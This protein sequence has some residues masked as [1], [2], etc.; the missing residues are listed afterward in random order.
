MLFYTNLKSIPNLGE[1][2]AEALA[3]LNIQTISDLLL[4]FPCNLITKK[5]NPP[6]YS[7]K[8][9]DYVILKLKIIDIDLPNDAYKLRRKSFN[10]YCENETGK[11]DLCYFNYHPQYLFNWAKI[12]S[13]I[14][15]VGK[16]E[17]F[18]TFKKIPHPEVLRPKTIDIPNNEIIYPLTYGIVSKQIAKYIHTIL[19]HLKDEDEW[20]D[21]DILKKYNWPSFRNALIEIHSPKNIASLSPFNPARQ[22]IAFDELL[23]TQLIVH[24]MRRLRSNDSGRET[25]ASGAL[26]K[27]F[28]EKLPFELTKGQKKAIEEITLDQAS[29]KRMARLLQGDVGSGKTVIAIATML[30]VVESGKQSVLMAPTDILANQHY[31]TFQKFCEELSIK[32]ALLTGKTKAKERKRILTELENGEL[33]I[34]IGT[35]AVFQEKVVFYDLALVVIDEQHRFGVEQRLSLLNKGNNVDLLIMSATPIPRSLSLVLYGDMEVTILTDKPKSRIAILTSILSHTKIDETILSLEKILQQN[36][37]VYWICPLINENEMQEKTAVELRVQ[38]LVKCYPSMVTMV[39]GQLESKEKQ[40]ALDSFA[41]GVSKI[42]VATTVVEVGV[43]VPE[44]NLIIIENSESFGLAQL[45]Q[46]RGRVGRGNKQS[47]CILFY[48][49]PISK[50]A[51]ERL[52]VLRSSNDGFFLAEEDLKLRGA[53]DIVGTKQSGLP[54]FKAVDFMAHHSLITIA[55]MEAKR[56]LEE[57]PLLHSLHNQ[58]LKQLL[59]FFNLQ[60]DTKIFNC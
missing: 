9:G 1:K 13:E 50:I 23:A 27:L 17:I 37:R 58:S 3:R 42:L 35:H 26:V 24:L 44:A 45:H 33:H 49:S 60:L 20:I 59:S 32:F 21:K 31:Q 19:T 51:M 48:K 12:G 46:L 57:D 39:H 53:G 18:K 52:K 54:S 25:I 14:I 38:T 6:V 47:Y 34:L 43:D 15:A 22:R 16:V 40:A 41:Q 10:I 29:N 2:A 4:H 56:I 5:V 30:N 8:H 28:L 7:L 11:I 36:G 55:N